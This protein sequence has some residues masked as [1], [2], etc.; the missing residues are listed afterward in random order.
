MSALN[1]GG[2]FGMGGDKPNI[3]AV[4]ETQTAD[5][6]AQQKAHKKAQAKLE[7]VERRALIR[8]AFKA[9][10]P[11]FGCVLVGLLFA[12]LLVSLWLH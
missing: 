11:F 6:W 4:Q 7:R 8:A 12:M 3:K 9:Y 5:D 2:R 1:G 10:L